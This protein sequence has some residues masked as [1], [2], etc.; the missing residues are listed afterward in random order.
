[1]LKLLAKLISP[2]V[3]LRVDHAYG[4]FHKRL[5]IA[6]GFSPDVE[7]KMAGFPYASHLRLSTKPGNH[8]FS[9]S[10]VKED[11]GCNVYVVSTS[12]SK[13]TLCNKWTEKLFGEVPKRLY[14]T[15]TKGRRKR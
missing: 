13:V 12:K 10:H 4:F 6:T 2:D 3:T 8:D 7:L 5:H 9:L 14:V 11:E 1:M 15:V